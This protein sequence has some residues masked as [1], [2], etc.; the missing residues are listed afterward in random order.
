MNNEIFS[1]NL[2]RQANNLKFQFKE[3]IEHA[4]NRTITNEFPDLHKRNMNFQIYFADYDNKFSVT[5]G[6][7]NQKEAQEEFERLAMDR[8]NKNLEGLRWAIENHGGQQ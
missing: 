8:F 1:K 5:F 6:D 3:K 4:I 2:T 7:K